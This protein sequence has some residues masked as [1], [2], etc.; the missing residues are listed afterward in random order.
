M[1]LSTIVASAAAATTLLVL[2]VAAGA[3][4]EELAGRAL[5]GLHLVP[6]GPRGGADALAEVPAPFGEHGWLPLPLG[7]LD[8][9]LL[10]GA[11]PAW[12]SDSWWAGC[13]G[14]VRGQ[15]PTLATLGFSV[16]PAV[17]SAWLLWMP[18]KCSALACTL[19]ALA[20]IVALKATLFWADALPL[21]PRA[22]MTDD[23]AAAAVRRSL[24]YL[25]HPIYVVGRLALAS[26]ATP[27]DGCAAL[28]AELSSS[29][30]T[31]FASLLEVSAPSD[32][33]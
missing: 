19:A 30:T 20:A 1:K 18:F 17:L 7:L 24:L 14:A 3:L 31:A 27:F 12:R 16:L 26:S 15:L 10:W 8:V 6:L 4:L 33:F 28:G 32:G 2:G 25:L 5:F 29:P 21:L 13:R 23:A 9:A 11:K 22:R